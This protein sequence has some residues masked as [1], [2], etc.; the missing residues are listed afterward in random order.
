LLLYLLL[1]SCGANVFGQYN[2]IVHH[3]TNENG[4]PANGV[5]GIELDKQTG[6]LWIGTQAG[7]V[8]FDGRNFENFAS[9]KNAAV[10]SRINVM[11]RNQEGTIYCEDD[12]FSVYRIADNRPQFV[13]TD[14]LLMQPFLLRGGN[15]QIRPVSQIAER[16]R[17]HKR[18]SFL[19][20]WMVFHDETGDPAS[21]TFN[22][23]GHACHYDARND[24][25][26]YFA[27]DQN[28][29][30]VI[31]L[32]GHVYFSRENQE[33]WEYNDSLKNMVPVPVE[34]M[35]AFDP[36]AADQPLYIWKPGMKDPLLIYKKD[37][38][39]LRLTGN[40]LWLEPFCSNCVPLRAHIIAVQVWEEKGLIFLGS[41]I[42]G[43]YVVRRPFL[44]SVRPDNA[45]EAGTAE[46]VQAEITPGIVTTASGLS[47][48]TR[49]K[50][51]PRNN[52]I[53]FHLY[54]M[55]KDQRGD[56]WSHSKDTIIHYYKAGNRYAKLA[57][58]DG[59]HKM[60]FAETNGR[61]YVVSD[62]AIGEIAG[63][64][65]RRLY[66]LPY[67]SDSLKN[68]FNPDAA[69]EWQPGILAIAAEK[70]I[71][72][73]INKA[74]AP[75]T[76]HIPGLTAKVRS[77]LKYGDY[78][79]IGSYGQGFYLWKNGIV[80]KMPLDKNKYL[81]TA[82]CFMPDGKGFCWISTNHGLF[83]V[84]LHALAAAFENDLDEIYYH[85]F[86]KDDGLFNTELNGGCQPCALQLSSGLF[87]FP[88]MNGMVVFDPQQPH[89]SPP[90]GHIIIDEVHA[91]SLSYSA[92][93]TALFN[94][95]H[96]VHN[97]RFKLSVPEFGNRENIYFAYQLEPYSSKWETQ[98]IAQNNLLQ[99]GGL[100]PGT[101]T[102]HLRV[103]NG[104][105]PNQFATVQLQFRILLPWYQTWCFYTLCVLGFVLLTWLLVKWRTARITRRKKELQELVSAQT[106]NIEAQ[107]RQLE[108]QL[109]QLQKQQVRLEEDNTIKARLI[110]II[111]HDMISPLKF[112]AFMGKKLRDSSP[113]STSSYETANYIIT[114]A[115]ELEYLS[116]NILNWIRFHHR[117]LE[118]KPEKFNL[119][120]LITES[121]QIAAAL[122]KE[123]GIALSIDVPHDAEVFQYRHAVGVIIYNLVMNAV[124]YTAT[125]EIRLAFKPEPDWFTLSVA[126]TG[127]GMEPALV[128]RLNSPA[129]LATG[130]VIPATKFQ[131]G[132]VIIKEL[133]RLVNGSMVVE[134]TPGKGSKIT[135]LLLL[136]GG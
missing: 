9:Q 3:Y 134:S 75:D 124:K 102:L 4:L 85:Y 79:L 29:Q 42:N 68:S 44:Q 30:E 109:S 114:V 80:K 25:L 10:T 7:I 18:S 31:K 49:G 62:V 71:L 51:L 105:E 28:F 23:L 118:M 112:M 122:A 119:Y 101:Y 83:K 95:P 135:I 41:D 26:L 56:H 48:S 40:R 14:T 53:H 32:N 61:L 69:I 67:T 12:N 120:E 22:Y 136:A 125:G 128:E 37:I 76:I 117:S 108:K 58:N 47:F 74:S 116:M 106:R 34:G 88:S 133:L 20:N 52:K 55:Y 110:G 100:K 126:D 8:R 78:L 11:A 5:K 73:N 94:L 15:I 16:L 2:Y 113:P 96:D 77:L 57:L 65:Y 123:K 99:F 64:T 59:A 60:V 86:G 98:D 111:S 6:F 19:P 131:F 21:F 43:L 1:L 45:E 50:L 89:I 103:R 63:D 82:H 46:Y 13:M 93:D 129:S 132:Y 130:G 36:D 38:W 87:S 24:T 107:S 72:F 70:P 92:G 39:K 27:G 97:I 115:Q 91:D 90:A 84:S 66:A 17:H 35:P 33:L 81:A 54:N 121:V 104:F 127:M